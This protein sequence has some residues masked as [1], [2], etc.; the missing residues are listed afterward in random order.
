MLAFAGRMIY[1]AAMV[2]RPPVVHFLDFPITAG[3][4]L[5]AIGVTLLMTTGADVRPLLIFGPYFYSEPWRLLTWVLPH[6][7]VFHLLFNVFWLWVFGT[8]V[9]MN[10]GHALLGL[11]VVLLAAGSGAAQY[12]VT[13]GYVIGLSGVVY[14]LFGY[15]WAARRHNP[16]YRDAI[17]QQTVTILV[18]WFFIALVLTRVGV[19]NVANVAHGVGLGLGYLAGL[20][21]LGR[22]IERILGTAGLAAA[23]AVV[24]WLGPRGPLWLTL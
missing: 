16:R 5:A 23:T 17:D 13:A 7:G 18:A 12:F 1:P 6:G 24:L 21:F 4:A 10:F 20:A 14:G 11:L 8:Y 15:L 9:E 22:K 2:W 19:L 3:V